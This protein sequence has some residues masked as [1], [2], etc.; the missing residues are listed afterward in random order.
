MN[1][2]LSQKHMYFHSKN[3]Q[4]IFIDKIDYNQ[5]ILNKYK[6]EFFITDAI[7][8]HSRYLYISSYQILLFYGRENDKFNYNKHINLKDS[9]NINKFRIYWGYINT[10]MKCIHIDKNERKAYFN[11]NILENSPTKYFKLK[12]DQKLELNT[13]DKNTLENIKNFYN[14]GYMMY[15]NEGLLIDMFLI[16]FILVEPCLVRLNF[17]RYNYKIP[18]DL[19]NILTQG[20]NI[21]DTMSTYI[22]EFSDNI[23]TN[24]P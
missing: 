10:I 5:D 3:I 6:Y 23:L 14:L 9:I 13:T 12:V 1:S 8:E 2:L 16:N 7:K 17:E 19:L 18:K 22:S 20:K 11:F 24:N 15:R 4:K 21:F